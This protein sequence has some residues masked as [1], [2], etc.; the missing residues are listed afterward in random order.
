[1]KFSIE[2]EISFEAGHRLYNYE[3]K[4]K[5]LHGHNYKLKVGLSSISLNKD[6]MVRD[7]GEVKNTIKKYIDEHIDHGFILCAKDLEWIEILKEK[8]QKMY[9]IS[10]NPTGESLAKHFYY[11]FKKDF[12]EI[13]YIII[14]ETPTSISKFGD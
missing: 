8:K 7:F 5:F 1:M 12:P 6:D 2:K 13:N 4:C 11:L 9:V 3:G 10:D 14:E